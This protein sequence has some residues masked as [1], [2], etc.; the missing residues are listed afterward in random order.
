MATA[1]PS[2]STA[3]SSSHKDR[4]QVLPYWALV[5]QEQLITALELAFVNPA[6]GGVLISGPRGTAKSTAVRAFAVMAANELPVTLPLGATVDRVVGGWSVEMLLK[7]APEKMDGLLAAAAGSD[8][9]MLYVDEVNLLDDYL[10]DVLLDVAS[11]G[12]LHAEREGLTSTR[13]GVDFTLVGTMNPDEGGLRP[14]LLDRFGLVLTTKSGT[15]AAERAKIITAALRLEEAKAE[16]RAGRRHPFWDECEHR[17]L[18]ARGR[19]HSARRRLSSVKWEDIVDDCA[20]VA[21]GLGVVGHRGPLALVNAA[22][23][24]AALDN[25]TVATREDVRAVAGLALVH[26]RSKNESDTVPEWTAADE[27]AVSDILGG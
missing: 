14:Q 25:S 19:L 23:A 13:T 22:R 10:V 26:R 6:L 18:R 8:A 20:R 5:G 11:S 27:Q 2:E 9:K 21:E 4:P 15:A 3:E 12:I 1:A 17:E 7:G 16:A 24:R